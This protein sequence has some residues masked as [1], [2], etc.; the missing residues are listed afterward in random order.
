M[1]A[2]GKRKFSKSANGGQLRDN[3]GAKTCRAEHHGHKRNLLLSRGILHT[4]KNVFTNRLYASKNCGS[5]PSF[6]TLQPLRLKKWSQGCH[7]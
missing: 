1:G 5:R 3:G 2:R 4:T 7:Q 6:P